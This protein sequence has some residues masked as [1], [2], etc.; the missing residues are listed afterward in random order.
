MLKTWWY[1]G[2]NGWECLL[3]IHDLTIERLVAYF[4]W[5]MFCIDPTA[6]HM[7]FVMDKLTVGQVY[8]QEFRFS[9]LLYH[10]TE[11]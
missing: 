5:K 11:I 10:P 2:N 1:G 9:S 3:L 8:V 6:L 7:G 4:S